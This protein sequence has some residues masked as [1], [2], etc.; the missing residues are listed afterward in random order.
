MTTKRELAD[1]HAITSARYAQRQQ[2]FAR[3]VEKE[4]HIRGELQRIDDMDRANR[5]ARAEAIPMRAIG[6]DVIW[7]GWM[8]R[9]RTALNMELARVL[10]VKAQ[11]LKEVQRAYG[12]VLV[13]EE[14]QHDLNKRLANTAAA[15][16]LDQAIE[17][18]LLRQ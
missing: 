7:Q 3:L 11:H 16:E 10:A 14:M 15:A 5:S 9:S 8:G 1:L 13:V 2:S 17:Q 6:A 18:S 12:K 4:N